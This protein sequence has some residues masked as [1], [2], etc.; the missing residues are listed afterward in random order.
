MLDLRMIDVFIGV[1]FLYLLICMVCSI[2]RESIETILN[3]RGAN[4]EAAI[5][6]LFGVADGD[7]PPDP[8][9]G[10]G[11]DQGKTAPNKLRIDELYVHPLI[12]V[13]Y[14][15]SYAGK[16]QDPKGGQTN[17]FLRL[18]RI[19]PRRYL[20]E[21]IP[22]ATFALTLIDLVVRRPVPERAAEPGQLTI[23]SLR[24]SLNK[25]EN[26]TVK[27][28]LLVALDNAD[29]EMDKVRESIEAWFNSAMDAVS[30]RYRRHTSWIIFGIAIT[31]SVLINVDTFR[32][33]DYLYRNGAV[34]DVLVAQATEAA[35]RDDMEGFDKAKLALEATQ[36]P[37]GWSEEKRPRLLKSGEPNR[38]AGENIIEMASFIVGW[39]VT[40]FAATLG[41]PFWFDLLKR[42]M[43]VRSI[44]Q[45]AKGTGKLETRDKSKEELTVKPQV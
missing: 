2:I 31:V 8:V 6:E 22:S 11:G 18:S 5:G 24:Q 16:G 23:E 7:K 1:I 20:P 25:I 42:V 14:P 26:E 27:R 35:K 45:P 38:F 44:V 37:I 40:A 9:E 13:L 19:V 3:R 30:A 12:S 4:L 15:G 29:G 21:H 34:R 36:L 39:L 41:A 28:T 32:I 33:A 43:L 17:R 10:E